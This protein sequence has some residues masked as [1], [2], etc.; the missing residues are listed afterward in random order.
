MA[1]KTRTSDKSSCIIFTY[2]RVGLKT[3]MYLKMISI[4]T[5][6]NMIHYKSL[7]ISFPFMSSNTTWIT[8][9]K[10][11]KS[12]K[13]SAFMYLRRIA[14]NCIN[15]QKKNMLTKTNEDILV[16]AD[17]TVLVTRNS[18]ER[19]VRRQIKQMNL[20]KNSLYPYDSHL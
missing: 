19:E 20:A 17:S 14:N 12:I 8:R 18:R 3:L 16:I 9:E 11:P 4:Q 1:K 15:S 7:V 2:F 6:K 10:I 13:L 5:V